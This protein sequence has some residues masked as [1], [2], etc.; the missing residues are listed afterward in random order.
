MKTPHQSQFPADVLAEAQVRVDQLRALINPHVIT[1]SNRDRMEMLKMGDKTLSFVSK[2]YDFAQQNSEMIPP[3]LDLPAFAVDL[4]DATNL[5]ALILSC[6][7]LADALDDTAM[8]AGSEA[9][10]AALVFYQ[11]AKAAS[12]QHVNGAKEV[13]KELQ[14]RFPRGKARTSSMTTDTH[15]PDA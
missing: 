12:K 11:A 6:R 13:S 1:L 7:Q 8:I 4:A 9:Y 5:R 2:A 14:E 3:Y 10:N 15:T